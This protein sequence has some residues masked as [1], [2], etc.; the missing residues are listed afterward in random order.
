MQTL[1]IDLGSSAIKLS[2]FDASIDKGIASSIFPKKELPIHAKKPG[3]AEQN[4]E[5]WWQIFKSA[6]KQMAQEG[7][8]LTAIEAIGISYQM[9]GLVIVDKEKKVLRPSI[10]WCDSRAVEIGEKAFQDLGGVKALSKLLNSPANFTASK[11]AWV[12]ENE[13]SVF[14][15][16]HKVML[17]GDYLVMKLTG[18]ITTTA[19]A[20]SEGI[21][22]DFESNA[23]STDV[24]DVF[25]F[26]EKII[27]EIVPP[28]G[29]ALKI[30][31]AVA[32]ELGLDKSVNICYRAGDQ[33]NNAF[34]L[35]TLNPGEVA[36]TAGT[37]GVIYAV[38]EKQIC[39]IKSRINTFMHVNSSKSNPRNGILICVNGTGIL[40]SWLKKLLN[41][42]NGSLDYDTMN[43]RVESVKPG[44]D[45]LICIPFGNGAERMFENNV[46]GSHFLNLDFNRHSDPH[47]LR[48]AI[49]GV[50][51][52]LN[53]GLEILKDLQVPITTIRA[54]KANLFLSKS[55]REIFVNV[56]GCKLEL[57]DTNGALGAARGAALGAGY[58][59]TLDDAFDKLELIDHIIPDAEL[60]NHYRILFKEWKTT[61]ERRSF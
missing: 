34:S 13:P 19:C 4:P 12:K 52:A 40:Y 8:D 29:S 11:L 50:V 32:L 2:I 57:Y 5:T 43:A 47:M 22:W 30:D 21:M 37:S 33:P 10:I 26:D 35:R 25:G 31:E 55:F 56:T 15:D 6:L 18:H 48:A 39:D 1:G 51:Y 28:I 3:W 20:L 36:A 60:S 17:P 41:A 53:F 7:A 49:E 42:G 14:K 54:G 24:L 23:L 61:I 27:P 16:I 58:Y 44:S 45:G 46:L 38:T 59:K 9:H